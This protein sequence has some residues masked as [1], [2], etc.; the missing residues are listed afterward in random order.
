MRNKSNLK[1]HKIGFFLIFLFLLSGPPFVMELFP[2][3]P[4]WKILYVCIFPLLLVYSKCKHYNLLDQR[5]IKYLIIW[6][7][8]WS[9]FWIV[10]L[11]SVY[12]SRVVIVLLSLITISIIIRL[13]LKQFCK[14]YV[15]LIL[16]LSTLGTL[17]FFLVF[18]LHIRPLFE[19]IN[20]DGRPGYCF[21]ISCTNMYN[22]FTDIY[23]VFRYSG[24]F[25]EPGAM[26]LWGTFALLINKLILKNKK[27][28]VLLIITLL[29]TFSLG[30]Y[31][32]LVAYF[33][34]FYSIKVAKRYKVYSLIICTIVCY[35]I[36]TNN[37]INNLF[38]SR[39][40]YDESTGTFAGNNRANQTELA[41]Y[42]FKENYLFGLGAKQTVELQKKGKDVNDNYMSTFAKEGVLG[43]IIQFLPIVIAFV[44]L[45]KNKEALKYL[46]IV[47]LSFMHRE[48]TFVTFNLTMYVIFIEALYIYSKKTKKNIV[49]T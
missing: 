28:E 33:I 24:Y 21:V 3:M 14:Y 16:T 48:I 49:T 39:L 34:L 23:G 43:S 42:Y 20:A 41:T 22:S 29:F 19:Y 26:G 7:G 40:K 2:I 31:A 9:V 36:F 32:T 46:A 37:T 45:R 35:F 5:L 15:Y 10:H 4:G 17:C 25:D 8:G 30:F 27:V 47:C 6:G 13:G 12:L 44:R 11:D 1:D 38:F 18:F